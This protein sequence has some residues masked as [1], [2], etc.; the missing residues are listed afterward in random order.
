MS[1]IRLLYI[2]II[3][4]PKHQIINMYSER[5]DKPLRSHLSVC[6]SAYLPTYLPTYLP[7]YLSMALQ[8]FV[9]PWPLFSFFI[10]YTV[11][12]TPWT[13]DQPV[14]RPLL[15]HRIT[16]TQNK[17]TQTLTPW[18]EF[19]PTIPAFERAKTVHALDRAATVVGLR[20]H[21]WSYS[22]YECLFLHNYWRCWYFI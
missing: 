15:T 16:Q 10:F 20:S 2:R 22:S 18:M 19:E 17:C 12:R 4:V 11:G 1:D 6:L 9:G 21:T 8:P 14:A 7:I 3:P 5:E 13:G